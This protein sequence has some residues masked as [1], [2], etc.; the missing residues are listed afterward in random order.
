MGKKRIPEIGEKA[1]KK[2]AEKTP[3]QKAQ[4][5]KSEKAEEKVAEKAE[6]PIA[7]PKK[8][9][10]KSKKFPKKRAQKKLRS[11]KYQ[12]NREL[13]DKDKTYALAE[14]IQLVKKV[15]YAKFGGSIEAHIRLNL[16]LGKSE[17]Q[18]RTIIKFPKLLGKKPKILALTKNKEAAL[19]AGALHVGGEELIEK[20]SQGF[21]DF[22]LVIS[23]PSF[24]PKLGKIA[25]ILG[26]KGMMPN[27]KT[28]TISEA[29]PEKI[30][31]ILQGTVEVKNDAVGIIHQV[32]GNLQDQ[33]A[34]LIKNFQILFEGIQKAK[35][36]TGKKD[37]IASIYL[38][39]TMG[40][41]VKI[42]SNL[43]FE[44]QNQK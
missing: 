32:I 38:S 25:R 44:K 16:N 30:Q 29:I 13:V 20:I 40:P 8:S 28:Q 15:S 4:E 24:M 19:K 43:I 41:S 3:I 18:I 14:A 23:E 42:D 22:N 2:S 34:V 9:T 37:F 7:E 26:T 11:Q 17:E 33:D 36:K 12:K 6:K 27:P 35:P 39:P 21:R 10:E 31:E 1:E 5:S